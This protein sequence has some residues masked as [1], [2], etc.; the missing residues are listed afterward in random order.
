MR[1]LLAGLTLLLAAALVQPAPARADE[2]AIRSVIE[3]QIDAFRADDETRAYSFA[4]PGIQR[5]FPSPERFMTMVRQG[6]PPVYR[7]RDYAFGDLRETTR[8]PVQEVTIVDE[9]GV[10]W[11]ALYALEQQPDDMDL[12]LRLGA[13]QVGAGQID[14]AEAGERCWH[15][16]PRWR[17]TMNTDYGIRNTGYGLRTTVHS[18]A[19]RPAGQRNLIGEH[20]MIRT[21]VNRDP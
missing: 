5:L 6:Y 17:V 13:A 12:L 8:G 7:P 10:T 14:D 4:A 18:L 2:G 20:A 19:D 11:Q 15:R 21:A 16:E 3:S 1:A 9:A